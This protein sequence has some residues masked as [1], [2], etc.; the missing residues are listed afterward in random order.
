[1]AATPAFVLAAIAGTGSN[2]ELCWVADSA[3]AVLPTTPNAALDATFKAAGYITQDGASHSNALA[4]NDVPV[5]GATAPVRTIVT[6]EVLT[7]DVTFMETNKVTGALRSRQALSAITVTSAIMN[8]TW[9]PA[10]DALY[11]LVVHAQD[12][13]NAAR[14][15]YPKVRVTGIG[16]QVK[17]YNG[18]IQY[19]MTFTAYLDGSGNSKYSYENVVGL[20]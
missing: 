1:M 12:S 19:P 9:G 3:G 13:A 14:D 17:G 20:T 4:Q 5:F 7:V 6:S 2:P 11:A 10:R 8:L 15:V 18:I 16:A